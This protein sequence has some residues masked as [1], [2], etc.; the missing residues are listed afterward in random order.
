MEKSN[1]AKILT[2]VLVCTALIG[3]VVG[4]NASAASEQT[5]EFISNNV[6]Y[7]EDLRLAYAVACEDDVEVTLYLDEALTVYWCDTYQDGTRDINGTECKKFYAKKGV[8]IQDIN[9]Y[10]YAV[11]ENLV[12]GDKD[13]QRYSVL[14][15]LYQRLGQVGETDANGN[16]KVT[17]NQKAMYE[18]HLA[19]AEAA[20]QV[21][22]VENTNNVRPDYS[23]TIAD[24][25]YV[26]VNNGLLEEKYTAG[27]Y[28]NGTAIFEHMTAN[29]QP[30]EGQKL[31][32][33]D[34]NNNNVSVN[35]E[36][37]QLKSHAEFIACIEV[38]AS[39]DVVVVPETPITYTFS[40][41]TAGTQYAENE[42]HVLDDN[43]TMYT[44]QAHFTAELRLYSSST[45]DGY[46]II[47]CTDGIGISSITLNAG[48]NADTIVI[49]GSNDGGETWTEAGS[50]TTASSY[51]DYIAELNGFY[52]YLKL[53]VR[54][55][56]QVRIKYMKITFGAISGEK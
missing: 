38:E 35:T 8:P 46:A 47:K 39:E 56:N 30:G 22:Y 54:G 7:G 33:R 12:T 49:Y 45:H 32:W 11:A 41:Y 13:I 5:V 21:I 14:E 28:A 20:E 48:N 42:E 9:T 29:E 37:Y 17:E 1:F 44:T 36:T 27:V 16:P 6:W 51:K 55:T 50:V 23:K 25:S 26:V 2:L 52:Q 4:I 15:Y 3:A 24:T 31:V 10:V 34:V 19:Y 18:A 53:D 40:N 43:I